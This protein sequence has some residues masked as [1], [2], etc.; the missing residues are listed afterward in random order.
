MH[1][2]YV[3]ESRS[4]SVPYE[5]NN[6]Q[7]YKAFSHSIK[8]KRLA[9]GMEQTSNSDPPTVQN[10]KQGKPWFVNKVLQYSIQQEPVCELSVYA[11]CVV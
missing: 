7:E 2:S 3:M 9:Y 11:S 10:A 4:E 5:N 8:L 1:S 6:F